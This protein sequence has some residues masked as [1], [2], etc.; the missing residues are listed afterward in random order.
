M[1]LIVRDKGNTITRYRKK[2][3]PLQ[4]TFCRF[5]RDKTYHIGKKDGEEILILLEG[6]IEVDGAITGKLERKNVFQECPSAIY[7]GPGRK[8]R[9]AA[10]SRGEFIVISVHA[11][12]PGFARIITDVEEEKRGKEGYLRTVF[13]I[14]PEQFPARRLV[15]GETINDAGNWSSFPPHK[16]DLDSADEVRMQEVYFYKVQPETGFG[17]QRI[18][19][20]LGLDQTYTIRNNDLVWI[21]RGYHPVTVMPGHRLYY[22]WALVGDSRELKPS[23]EAKFRWLL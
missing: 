16:H 14:L 17:F 19:D 2:S 1:N 9:V 15:V 4:V 13:N 21:P 3:V 6:H 23:T 18:Y 8:I 11:P 12:G 20:S 10:R 7:V 22:A 5:D